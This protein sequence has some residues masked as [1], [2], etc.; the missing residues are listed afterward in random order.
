MNLISYSLKEEL[1]Q[2]NKNHMLNISYGEFLKHT[3]GVSLRLAM[4]EMN[5]NSGAQELLFDLKDDGFLIGLATN[6]DFKVVDFVVKKFSLNG[7]FDAIVCGEDV[8]HGKPNPEIYIKVVQKLGLKPV[9]CVAI[10]DTAVGVRSVKSAGLKCIAF[11]NQFT[12][13]GS[14]KEADY[15]IN[16]LTELSAKKISRM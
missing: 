15:V 4:T 10:E 7:F 14:F 16:S 1:V 9:N 5:L 2:I 11:P 13:Y 8:V 3:L 12:R 6:N